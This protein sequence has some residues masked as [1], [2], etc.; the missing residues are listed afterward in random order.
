MNF[1][2]SDCSALKTIPTFDTSKVTTMRGLVSG[3]SSITEFPELDLSNVT[4]TYYFFRECRSLKSVPN[5]NTH[6]STNFQQAFYNCTALEEIG[7]IE[8]ESVTVLNTMLF[9]NCR[10]LTHFGGFN[11][12]GQ[13]YTTYAGANNTNY[14]L[15]MSPC[16]NLTEQSLINILT[17]LYDIKTKG[18]NT[19][20][21]VL[22]ATNLAKLTSEAGQQAL[23]QAQN[24]GW[25]IS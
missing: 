8:A 16:I 3:C 25:T 13:A 14:K 10:A 17:K 12:L 9:Q 21:V 19:Q 20:S 11:N 1:M 2:L 4:D 6:K 5:L 23:A 7:I 22:G 15:D 24:Y 18:C